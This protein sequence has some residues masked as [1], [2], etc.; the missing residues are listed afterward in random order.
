MAFEMALLS[1]SK[2]SL[3]SKWVND[4]VAHNSHINLHG[5]QK[6]GF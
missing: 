2:Y 6:W 4:E 5:F 1:V 3:Y